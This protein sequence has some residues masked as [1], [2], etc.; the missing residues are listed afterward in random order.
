MWTVAG[1]IYMMKRRK[2]AQRAHERGLRR[3]ELPPRR[4]VQVEKKLGEKWVVPNDPACTP[5]ER[6]VE[7]IRIE[8]AAAQAS[9]VDRGE[10]TASSSGSAVRKE[11]RSGDLPEKK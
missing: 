5:E 4:S 9:G 3:R 10:A 2:R 1:I 6:E 8:V 11:N 7:R